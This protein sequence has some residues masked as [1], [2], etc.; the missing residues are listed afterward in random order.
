MA[1][2]KNLEFVSKALWRDRHEKTHPIIPTT[3]GKALSGNPQGTQGRFYEGTPQI[4]RIWT[5][6]YGNQEAIIKSTAGYQRS[7]VTGG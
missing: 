7:S 4:M 3:R 1:E 6:R 5:S 2:G